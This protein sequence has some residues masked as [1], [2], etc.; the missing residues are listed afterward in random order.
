MYNMMHGAVPA[1]PTAHLLARHA[2]AHAPPPLPPHA[3]AP[4]AFFGN[5]VQPPDAELDEGMGQQ[6]GEG[7]P[8]LIDCSC[9]EG[10]CVGGTIVWLHGEDLVPGL[11]VRFGGV[12]APEIQIISSQLIK[13]VAPA[14]APMHLQP[15]HEVAITLVGDSVPLA[16][17]IP[18][19][20]IAD[21]S[22]HGG[23]A[24]SDHGASNVLLLRLFASLERAQAAAAATAAAPAT[25]DSRAPGPD[26]EL[27]LSAFNAMDEHGYSLAE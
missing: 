9:R 10:P 21:P 11:S 5:A 6:F 14:F 4:I 8:R 15:R 13:C 24:A 27:S 2:P 23:A 17:S 7:M 20:Y 12:A 26:A 25:T 18:F 1:M 3:P 19:A 22:T 16:G